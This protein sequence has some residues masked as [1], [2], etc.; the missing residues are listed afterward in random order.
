MTLLLS[1]SFGGNADRVSIV[2]LSADFLELLSLSVHWLAE[3][4]KDSWWRWT[5]A[6]E[7]NEDGRL[8]S[9]TA[10]RPLYC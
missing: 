7:A 5:P 3:I 1:K 10:A 2:V 8:S 9:S 6:A 4:S